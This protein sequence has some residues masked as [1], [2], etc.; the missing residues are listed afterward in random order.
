VVAS[1]ERSVGPCRSA[2]PHA[3]GRVDT[4]LFPRHRRR[5]IDQAHPRSKHHRLVDVVTLFAGIAL[6]SIV[7]IGSTMGVVAIDAARPHARAV[8]AIELSAGGASD[9]RDHPAT[10]LAATIPATALSRSPAVRAATPAPTKAPAATS[11]PTPAPVATPALATSSTSTKGAPRRALH[12][13][14]P[15]AAYLGDS[16]TTGWSGAGI[17]KRGWPAIVSASFGWKTVNRAVAGT[18]F[19]NPGWTGQRIR[20]R[21][22]PVLKSRPGIVFVAGGH[23]DRRFGSRA[24]G[25]A[26]DAVLRRLRRELPDAVIVVIGPIWAN[27]SPPAAIRGIRAELRRHA[28]AVGAIFVDPIREGWFAGSAER[29]ILADGIHPSNA[30]HR[31]IAA[32]VL[33]ALDALR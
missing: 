6:L 2:N 1:R 10:A 22:T 25:K 3:T 11:A 7:T 8:A 9:E 15:V 19:V 18:G 28:A 16:Y 13:P 30:G 5:R 26:A 20:S 27:G 32:R 24:A 23:N 17:G 14:R 12:V 4:S 33:A 31:R 29:L 21:V